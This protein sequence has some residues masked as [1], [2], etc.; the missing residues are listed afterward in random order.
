MKISILIA[1]LGLANV[2][3]SAPYSVMQ[4]QPVISRPFVAPVSNVISTPHHI[5]SHFAVK[6]SNGYDYTISRLK[7]YTF[8]RFY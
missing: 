7:V 4:L 3:L 6:D 2:A 5:Q 1:F 8:M